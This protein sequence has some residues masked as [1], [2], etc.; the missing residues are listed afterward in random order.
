MLG[1]WYEME[2]S[3]HIGSNTGGTVGLQP[4]AINYP[5]TCTDA[6]NAGSTIGYTNTHCATNYPHPY[7]NANTYSKPGCY[8]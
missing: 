4:E 1:G 3:S 2:F 8:I 7:T 5:I 6:S